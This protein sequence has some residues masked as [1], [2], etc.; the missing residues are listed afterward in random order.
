MPHSP[1]LVLLPH[2]TPKKKR[3]YVTV[4]TDRADTILIF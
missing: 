1:Y 2:T 4:N 3:I